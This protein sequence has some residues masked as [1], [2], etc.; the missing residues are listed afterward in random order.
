MMGNPQP[1]QAVRQPRAVFPH[2]P[3]LIVPRGLKVALLG[4]DIISAAPEDVRGV[5]AHIL[6][7]AAERPPLAGYES[8]RQ[9]D[10]QRLS[11]LRQAVFDAEHRAVGEGRYLPAH[12]QLDKAPDHLRVQT[13]DGTLSLSTFE[14]LLHYPSVHRSSHI[15][16]SRAFSPRLL[17]AFGLAPPELSGLTQLLAWNLCGTM[18]PPTGSG[19]IRCPRLQGEDEA[20][21]YPEE[22]RALYSA[23]RADH[24]VDVL[25][26]GRTKFV[27]VLGDEWVGEHIHRVLQKVNEQGQGKDRFVLTEFSIVTPRLEEWEMGIEG[28][29]LS[30]LLDRLQGEVRPV[31]TTAELFRGNASLD[32][33]WRQAIDIDT[34]PKVQL[35]FFLLRPSP[36][37]RPLD[38][39]LQATSPGGTEPTSPGGSIL[40]LHVPHPS[41]VNYENPTVPP[42]QYQR[43]DLGV[44]LAANIAFGVGTTGHV[45]GTPAFPFTGHRAE[46]RLEKGAGGGKMGM[47]LLAGKRDWRRSWAMV[48]NLLVEQDRTFDESGR[49]RTL[50]KEALPRSLD[51]WLA[52]ASEQ[53]EHQNAAVT[54]SGQGGR[55]GKDVDDDVLRR[56]A[57]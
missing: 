5:V 31:E 55:R 47:A 16:T 23:H 21:P 19:G 44:Q 53:E 39:C 29:S 48:R 54:S 2:V 4:S 34:R 49:V 56:L 22:I 11:A 14:V 17:R 45:A 18:C 28:P 36:V 25:R 38:Q 40:F 24:H 51:K 15:L 7:A 33:Q 35:D 26:S 46:K 9:L 30:T 13:I 20:T 43:L 37:S 12:F 6:A 1:D 10:L 27:L 8:A 52:R 32:K 3:N 41:I 50:G 42:E 57:D